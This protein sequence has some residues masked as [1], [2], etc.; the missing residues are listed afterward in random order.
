MNK[1]NR[2]RLLSMLHKHEST[3]SSINEFNSHFS[4]VRIKLEKSVKMINE[5]SES[6]TNSHLTIR[7]RIS[8]ANNFD[9]STFGISVVY[10]KLFSDNPFFSEENKSVLDFIG[11]EQNGKIKIQIDDNKVLGGGEKQLWNDHIVEL[12]SNLI[13][14]V[15]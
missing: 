3:I 8:S 5:I 1:E 7:E 4:K 15:A 11:D 14:F 2:E 9:N 6:K 12:T 13:G 10:E